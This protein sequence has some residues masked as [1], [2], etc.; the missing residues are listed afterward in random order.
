MENSDLLNNDLQVSPLS[1]SFLHETARWGKFL[2]II[3]FIFSGMLA[4]GSFF[5][6][7]LY[8]KTTAFS[9]LDPS[10]TTAIS[11]TIVVVYLAFA[12]L[13]FFPCLYLNR[14]SVKM[15]TALSSMNQEN[16]EES[17]QNLKSLF[18]FYGIFTIII[19]SFYILVFAIAILVA[20]M[21]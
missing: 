10:V 9:E 2:S 12:I 11:T 13:L 19:L 17:F 1:Q 18:K 14:F 3:G 20:V 16:L 15:R 4:I 8:S 21:R 5:A 6:P 7:A